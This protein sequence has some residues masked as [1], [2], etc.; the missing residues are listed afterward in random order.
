MPNDDGGVSAALAGAKGT[1]KNA[2]NFTHSVTGSN[3]DANYA[4]HKTGV[5][6]AQQH[7]ADHQGGTLGAELE[8]KRAN[9]NAYVA[10]KD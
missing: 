10:D 3:V 4:P 5:S 8:A 7:G 6:F 9:V 1:L 2:Q